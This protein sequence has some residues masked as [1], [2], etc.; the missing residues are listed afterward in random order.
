MSDVRKEVGR[1]KNYPRQR[2]SQ[3][4]NE[5][6]EHSKRETSYILVFLCGLKKS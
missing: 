1:E 3:K 2:G 6:L 5:D 4:A